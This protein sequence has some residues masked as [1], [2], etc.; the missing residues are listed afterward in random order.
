MGNPNFK[1]NKL[2]RFVAK[3][4]QPV[5]RILNKKLYVSLQ[6]RYITGHKLDWKHLNLYTEKLQY[7]R[8][9]VYPF[10][11]NVI[12]TASRRGAREYV[13]DKG[14]GEI[15]IPSLGIFSSFDE[16]N[17]EKLPNK[18]VMKATHASGFNYICLDKNTLDISKLRKTFNKYLKTDYGRQTVEPH[19]SKIKP[20]IIIEEYIGKQGKLPVEYKLHVFNGK[21]K[22]LY[23][24]TGRGTNIRYNNFYAD[25]TPFN[26]AQ[27]NH[28]QTSAETIMPPINFKKM[29]KIAEDLSSPFPFVRLDFYEVDGKIYFGEF[30]FT[31]A[32]G[33]LVFDNKKAD[34]EIGSWLDISRL[35]KR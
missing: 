12:K 27:F 5:L 26:D 13:E 18:F 10:D 22:Y 1:E 33:T 29:I 17:F 30:T 14:Y 2:K 31:P 11:K 34:D 9:Y 21:V 19:Y 32:K 15:L 16:I 20:E 7:L 35:I 23:V 4:L 3:A 6:Y 8:L 24:V 28:W 25:W